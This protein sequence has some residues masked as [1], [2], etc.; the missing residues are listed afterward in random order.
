MR[1]VAEA[2]QT[3]VPRP[4][5][6]RLRDFNSNLKEPRIFVNN[7]LQ[8]K[9]D[10]A[11]KT[12]ARFAMNTTFG[13]GGLVD[14]ASLEGN[15]AADRRL[16]AD[17]VCLGCQRRPLYGSTLLRSHHD[18]RCRRRRCRS[19]WR[20]G[21]LA[22]RNAVGRRGYHGRP[23]HGCQAR[24]IEASRRCF[25]RLLQLHAFELLPNAPSGVT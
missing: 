23:R 13:I 10:A 15:S 25:H 11:S 20:S 17:A 7:L 5:H 22:V 2:V 4:T 3:I 12:A 19:L 9:L 14:L 24:P 18:S 1:P 21:R 16:W 6:D 8:G